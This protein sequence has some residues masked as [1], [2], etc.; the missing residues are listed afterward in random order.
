MIRIPWYIE[1]IDLAVLSSSWSLFLSLL[2]IPLDDA[3][4]KLVEIGCRPVRHEH[5]A[6]L[7][8]KDQPLDPVAGSLHYHL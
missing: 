8:S 4:S 1:M 2:I 6:R 7:M 3:W 5:I